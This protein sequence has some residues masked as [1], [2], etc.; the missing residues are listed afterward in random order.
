ML[1]LNVAVLRVTWE[2]RL[3]CIVRGSVAAFSP[4]LLLERTQKFSFLPLPFVFAKWPLYLREGPIRQSWERREKEG[5]EGGRKFSAENNS[6]SNNNRPNFSDKQRQ[7]Y[8]QRWQQQ[9]QDQC[10]S[11][12][13]QQQPALSCTFLRSPTN[14]TR[15]L[16]TVLLLCLSIAKDFLFELWLGS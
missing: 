16:F 12:Q 1:L 5:E 6:S 4:L 2:L 15:G 10:D 9:Q 13:R 7:Q 11:L 8:V 14:N 3:C